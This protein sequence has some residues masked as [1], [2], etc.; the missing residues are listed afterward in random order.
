M[1]VRVEGQS[2]PKPEFLGFLVNAQV[3][4]KDFD[5]FCVTTPSNAGLPG[6]GGQKLCGLF[7]ITPAARRLPDRVVTQTSNFGSRTSVYNGFDIGLSARFGDGGFATGGVSSGKTVDDNCVVV[8]SPQ[9]HYCKTAMPFAAQAQVKA[10]ASYPL[11]GGVMV[12][13]VLQNLPGPS[14]G[15]FGIFFGGEGL[16][17]GFSSGFAFIPMV[18]P[19]TLFEARFTQA[20]LRLSK[21]FRVSTGKIR[22]DFDLFNIANSRAILGE[23]PTYGVVFFPGSQPGAGWRRPSSVLG[24]RMFKFGGQIDF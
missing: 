1:F 14:Y 9:L 2:K 23:D 8:D 4:P 7:D 15:A 10:N 17:R 22:V 20:D 21:I 18:E 24:G 5:P 19:N 3:G 16:A 11:P 12:S 6:G 13:G